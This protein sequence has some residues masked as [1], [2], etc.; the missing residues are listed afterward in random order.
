MRQRDPA[1]RQADGPLRLYLAEDADSVRA[2]LSAWAQDATRGWSIDT[3]ASAR[4]L[5]RRAEYAPPDLAL[6]DVT[7]PG[8]DGLTALRMLR[9][10][11]IRVVLLSPTTPD[12]ARSALEGLI[13]GAED[14]LWKRGSGASERLAGSRARF[15]ERVRQAATSFSEEACDPSVRRLRRSEAHPLAGEVPA[16]LG[17]V[18]ARPHALGAMLRWLARCPIVPPAGMLICAPVPHRVG[19]VFAACAARLVQRPVLEI[20]DGEALRSGWWR[21]VTEGTLAAPVE[22]PQGRIW[23]VERSRK[24][25]WEN[26]IRRQAALLQDAQC[27][28]VRLIHFGTSS[29][30]HGRS[31]AL[32][33]PMGR[34]GVEA[35]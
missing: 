21:L 9:R 20:A 1:G 2:Q 10:A 33:A 35:A 30:R 6:L 11:R 32:P 28:E 7:L 5:L 13:E 26:S 14:C 23:R 22:G 12:A 19:P 16:W 4:A 34:H 3:F 8:L 31:A 29:R 17:L 27:D 15:A 18:T 24:P 25:D